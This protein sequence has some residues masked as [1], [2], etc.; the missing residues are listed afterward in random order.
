MKHNVLY[1]LCIFAFLFVA[2]N[3]QK[4][5]KERATEEQEPLKVVFM[6]NGNLGDLSFFDSANRGMSMLKQKYG[7]KITV[8]T[9]EASTDDTKWQPALEDLSDQDWDVIIV[10][11]F[12][13][14]EIL[15]QVASQYPEKRY[16]IFDGVVSEESNVYS[17]VYKQNEA[18]FLAGA[19][20]AK[21]TSLKNNSIVNAGEK[22]IAFLGG[23]EIPVINDFL[24]GYIE[25]A[26]YSEPDI[27]VLIS[28]IG[29]F[30]DSAKGKELALVQYQQ[31]A[32]IGFNVAGAAGL[33]QLD[34]AKEVGKYAIGVDS[35]QSLLF[36]SSDP[37]KAALIVTSA[38]K[39]VDNSLVR[40]IDKH[41]DGSLP[42]GQIE[43]L[44]FAD[45]AVG[46][47]A[48]DNYRDIVPE[49]VRS[50]IEQVR[51]DISSGVIQVSTAFGMSDEDLN[52]LKNSVQ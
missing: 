52:K 13:M 14:V 2:C 3:K 30:D 25:G 51:S 43:S 11:T 8:K 50:Y 16:I 49:D 32:D 7:N 10:G 41:L 27:E 47:A 4:Q 6:V 39:R 36:K 18:S 1:F 44:G 17:I 21:V 28:Y 37:E 40:A 48:N 23:L 19:V 5:Q 31:G 29:S 26:K 35:D 12:T 20:A 45:G 46:I 42:Y 22:K 9:I 38:L 24:V 33:G 15:K 34:A